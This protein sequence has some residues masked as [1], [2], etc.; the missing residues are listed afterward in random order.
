MI[1]LHAHSSASD[2]SYSPEAL[3][4]MAV[5]RDLSVL[6]LTDHDTIAGVP[7]AREAAKAAGLGFVAGIE[8]DIEWRPGEC[9]LLGYGLDY[10]DTGLEDLLVR[11]NRLRRERNLEIVERMRSAG[12]E[13][14]YARVEALA[15]GGTV[16][17]PH[18]ARH[19][20][21][22]GAVKN[23]QQAFDRYLAKDRPFFIDRK[24]I[25]LD[26]GIAVI[27]AAGGVPVLAHPLS[28]Y[29]S[30]GRMQEVI[31]N[32]RDRG[33][34]GLEAW[35]P[36]VRIVEGE[37]LEALA[38]SL[39]LFVTAGSDFHGLA[40]PERKLGCTAGRRVIDDRFYNDE[41]APVLAA[42]PERV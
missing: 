9:H 17:R 22:L 14:D 38:R 15:A 34:V 23:V 13:A 10:P 2:G 18:F 16:G 30:W 41:L 39:G 20:V 21:E 36:A 33:L 6:A 7:E 28:L 4:A 3:V 31:S 12:I 29:V 27:R 25:T 24:S 37:R 5:E 26:E 42:R 8:L 40:R 11:V 1:D 35:H 19:L 32:F